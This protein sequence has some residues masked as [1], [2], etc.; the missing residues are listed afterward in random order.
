MIKHKNLCDLIDVGN[1]F[2]REFYPL[3][4]IPQGI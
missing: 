1:Y 3:F 4:S 2:K